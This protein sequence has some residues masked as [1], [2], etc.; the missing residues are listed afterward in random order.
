MKK[1]VCKFDYNYNYKVNQILR[2]LKIR[3]GF[4]IE[5]TGRRTPRQLLTVLQ[6][7]I[8]GQ[9]IYYFDLKQVIFFQP[10]VIMNKL[11]RI[12]PQLFDVTSKLK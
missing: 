11:R 1:S 6:I 9:K 4:L 12:L 5:A 3:D 2:L 8:S 7:T 10:K